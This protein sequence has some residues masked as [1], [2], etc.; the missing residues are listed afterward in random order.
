M[1]TIIHD[2]VMQFFKD[3]ELINNSNMIYVVNFQAWLTY[4]IYFIKSVDAIYLDFQMAF[5]KV[6]HKQLFNR[7][8]T[9][10]I[11]GNIHNWLQDWL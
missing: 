11:S 2:N 8:L 1:V 10:G 7:Q 6:P 9:H 3:N 4:S 5:D